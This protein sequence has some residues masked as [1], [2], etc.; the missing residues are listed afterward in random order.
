MVSLGIANSMT[1]NITA[2]VG[3]D[4]YMVIRTFLCVLFLTGIFFVGLFEYHFDLTQILFGL[5]LT[6]I[7]YFALNFLYRGLN[8]GKIGL[9][10][11]VSSVNVVFAILLTTVFLGVKLSV[12]QIIAISAIVAGVVLIRLDPKALRDHLTKNDKTSLNYALIS[13][14][15]MGIFLFA[16][17]I[18][19]RTL[20]PILAPITFESGSFLVGSFVL[21]YRKKKITLPEIRTSVSIVIAIALVTVATVGLYYGLKNGNPA[22][23]LALYSSNPIVATVY[24]A[25]VH[26]ERLT[27]NQYLAIA[28]VVAGVI[29]LRVFS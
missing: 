26:K 19:T 6:L 20:G 15:L 24:G 16:S 10:S 29:S 21:L 7:G 13:G 22:I 12:V 5:S 1:K 23:I 4:Q 25:I 3:V 17:Q 14:V 8:I 11:P 2:K 28:I 27:F 9:V 18:P